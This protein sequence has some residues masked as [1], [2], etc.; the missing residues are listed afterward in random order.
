[1]ADSLLL[2]TAKAI[3]RVDDV[4]KKVD[5]GSL[6]KADQRRYEALSAAALGVALREPVSVL[7]LPV[8]TYV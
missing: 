5:W 7:E 4:A 8:S 1:M 6:S 2:R 3:Y